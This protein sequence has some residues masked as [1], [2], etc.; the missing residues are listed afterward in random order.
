MA[1][2]QSNPEAIVQT[3]GSSTA[4]SP[5]GRAHSSRL[6]SSVSAEP[7]SDLGVPPV[8]KAVLKAKTLTILLALAL[9][10]FILW[11]LKHLAYRAALKV[12]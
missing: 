9:L 5:I 2:I 7:M 4:V 11:P 6:S 3:P 8:M 1:A 12:P 10:A